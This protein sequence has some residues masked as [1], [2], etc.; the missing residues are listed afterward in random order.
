MA[1]N[2]VKGLIRYKTQPTRIL[3]WEEGSYP[4]AEIQL[5]YFTA[6]ADWAVEKMAIALKQGFSSGPYRPRG[7]VSKI[8]AG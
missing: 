7:G 2:N 1:L 3:F 6:L 8:L 5:A 4:I